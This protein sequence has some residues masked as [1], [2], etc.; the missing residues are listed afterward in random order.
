MLALMKLAWKNDIF[1]TFVVESFKQKQFIELMKK[2]SMR[3]ELFQVMIISKQNFEM[4]YISTKNAFVNFNLLADHATKIVDLFRAWTQM[5]KNHLSGAV[6]PRLALAPRNTKQPANPNGER[7]AKSY[8]S[9][10]YEEQ[11]TPYGAS[12]PENR[13]ENASC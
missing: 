1:T 3:K 7:D 12:K 4:N 8:F 11:N 9:V 5:V 6:W 10:D 13:R 2:G